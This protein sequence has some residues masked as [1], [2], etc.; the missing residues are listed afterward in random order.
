MLYSACKDT[1]KKL[2]LQATTNK[3]GVVAGL[4]FQPDA[5]CLR[6]GMAGK[7]KPYK[8]RHTVTGGCP[9]CQT[10]PL[11]SLLWGRTL[12][13]SLFC[14]AKQALLLCKTMGLGTYCNR[15]Y[16]A[17]SNSLRKRTSFSENKRRSL[18]L[19]FRLVMRSTPMPKA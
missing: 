12:Q 4:I 9:R 1:E 8:G 2:K 7:G 6:C 18:T 19:Y 16:N 10:T 5:L 17:L 15:A 13:K 14:V 11:R 3:I